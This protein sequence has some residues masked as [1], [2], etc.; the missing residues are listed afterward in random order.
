MTTLP[1]WAQTMI[2]ILGAGF[3]ANILSTVS[4]LVTNRQKNRE[5]QEV[6]RQ[7]IND[8]LLQNT[9][10]HLDTLYIPI[11]KG[12]SQLDDCYQT[13]KRRKGHLR[14]MRNGEVSVSARMS[15]EETYAK[16]QS[17]T[18]A[19]RHFTEEA[20][21]EL[22]EACSNF[23]KLMEEITQEG[24]DVYLPM[25]FDER[26]RSLLQL[27]KAAAD[28]R[29][30]IASTEVDIEGNLQIDGDNFEKRFSEDMRYLRSY[31]KDVALG[32]TWHKL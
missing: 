14:S 26:L 13:Y 1:V 32:T 8:N 9:R 3:V 12:L 17:I 30:L 24:R 11:N 19:Y 23:R 22:N 5:L 21:D 7:R 16:V 29:I 31:I 4:L 10:Q 25:E 6:K 28:D 20:L 15:K 18:P 2:Y 27:L